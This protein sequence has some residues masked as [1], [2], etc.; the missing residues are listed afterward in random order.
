MAVAAR[1]YPCFERNARRIWAEGHKAGLRINQAATLSFFLAQY[2]AKYTSF[3]FV[4]PSP[5][6]PQL[7]EN[8]AWQEHGGDDLRIGMIPLTPSKLAVVFRDADI[9]ET[10]I[11]F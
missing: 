4:I 6:G 1:H 8:T 5:R 2:I 11:A 9:S 3:L 10:R 7:I